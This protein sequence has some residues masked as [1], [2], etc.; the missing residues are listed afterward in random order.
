M[1]ISYRLQLFSVTIGYLII[2]HQVLTASSLKEIVFSVIDVSQKKFKAWV[3]ANCLLNSRPWGN[4]DRQ[5]LH[6]RLAINLL[7]TVIPSINLVLSNPWSE[8]LGREEHAQWKLRSARIANEP[9]DLIFRGKGKKKKRPWKT[10]HKNPSLWEPD[11]GLL[12]SW[13]GLLQCLFAQVFCPFR[14]YGGWQGR[15]SDL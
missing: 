14:R 1:L 5:A 7:L 11:Y 15:D 4:G 3:F 2:A 9:P 6:L 10:K 8:R 13:H 12:C